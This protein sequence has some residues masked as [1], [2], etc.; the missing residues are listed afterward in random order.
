ML[1][2]KTPHFL[3]LTYSK[4]RCLYATHKFTRNAQNMDLIIQTLI[5]G[6]DLGEDRGDRPPQK[7][8]WRG[9]KCFYLPQYLENV[10]QIYYVKTNKNEKED[11]THVTRD[12]HTSII[13]FHCLD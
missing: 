6:G 7:V 3:K 12:R 11:E 5:R 9:Q 1:M 2:H 13:L 8:R 4:F 10:L